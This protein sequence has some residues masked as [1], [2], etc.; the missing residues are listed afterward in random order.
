MNKEINQNQFQKLK[1][2]KWNSSFRVLVFGKLAHVNFCDSK[3]Y[4]TKFWWLSKLAILQQVFRLEAGLSWH[5]AE[6]G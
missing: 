1:L 4:F 2:K 5:Q 6:L 3:M